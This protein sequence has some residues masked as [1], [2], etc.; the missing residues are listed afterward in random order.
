MHQYNVGATFDRVAVDIVGPFPKSDRGNRYLLVAMDYFT[1]ARGTRHSEPGGID[2][3]QRL[4]EL[5]SFWCHD[6]ITQQPGAE[7]R[8]PISKEDSGTAGGS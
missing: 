2:S 7:L 1:V 8:V 3:S 6:G 5:L 4:G